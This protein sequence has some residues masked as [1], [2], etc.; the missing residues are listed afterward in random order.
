MN[1]HLLTAV[2]ATATNEDHK[3]TAFRESSRDP[4]EVHSVDFP[5]NKPARDQ[6]GAL[7]ISLDF[8]L[9]WG[10][11]DHVAL[12]QAQRAR[13]LA[14]RAG[15]PRLLD[16]FDEFSVHATWATVGLLFAR[17]RQEAEAFR[18]E[19]RPCYQNARLDPYGE[20][21]GADEREDPFHFAP[22]LIAQIAQRAGQEIASHSFCHYYGMEMG[23]TEAEF[24]ADL[25]SAVAIAANSGYVLRSYVF[26]RNQVNPRYLA[27][28]ERSGIWTYRGNESVGFR[29]AAAFAEQRRPYKRAC[30]LLDS[31]LDIYG[32]QCSAW[33]GRSRPGHAL[34]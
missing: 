10:V 4:A 22:S 27:A 1:S 9:H 15:I 29:E 18:P 32:H 21:L 34:H 20:P 13:L 17:S 31:F 16:L 26:P 2:R 23:Q 30:R 25:K 19:V 8:E 14:A 28:L 3:S 24:A 6:A 33:P 7:V 12:D 11:R 5:S